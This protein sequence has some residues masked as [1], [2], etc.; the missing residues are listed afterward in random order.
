LYFCGALG[1]S[2][3]AVQ[4]QGAQE[5]QSPVESKKDGAE[6]LIVPQSHT[7]HEG[8]PLIVK[9]I[10]CNHGS[11]VIE[12]PRGFEGATGA[13]RLEVRPLGGVYKHLRTPGFGSSSPVYAPGTPWWFPVPPGSAYASYEN[14]PGG[15]GPAFPKAG[16]YELRAV[17]A[18]SRQRIASESV[19]IEVLPRSESEQ[20]ILRRFGQAGP[21]Q[22]DLAHFA[23]WVAPWEGDFV[24]ELV[25][26]ED[27]LEECNYKRLLQ[28]KLAAFV[29][30]ES[31]TAGTLKAAQD[32][33]DKLYEKL[34]PVSQEVMNLILAR[35]Y[36]DQ[37]NKQRAKEL[38]L[39][40]KD[41][42]DIRED[43]LRA[44]AGEEEGQR[45]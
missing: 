14:I 1:C 5:E 33:I 37:G 38:L 18:L 10:A 26:L 9:V 12:R 4:P 8:D 25:R 31:K 35:Q 21:E 16:K 11:A 42:S 34:D 28:M 44:I 45:Q 41:P 40:V 29:L 32:R 2:G 6:L 7:I 19:L 23:I 3:A 36:Y 30:R 17:T 22:Q 27:R 39:R 24:W 13:I 15:N 43:L 20:A